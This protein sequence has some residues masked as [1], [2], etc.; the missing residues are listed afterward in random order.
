MGYVMNSMSV[1]RPRVVHHYNT[2]SH[3]KESNTRKE[4]DHMITRSQQKEGHTRKGPLKG[5]TLMV[6][7]LHQKESH[8]HRDKI[9]LWPLKGGTPGPEKAWPDNVVQ[10][11]YQFTL[12]GVA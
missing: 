1:N 11:P 3:Q 2:R 5:G 6:I 8:T 10:C 4:R 7:G 12:Q 9:C